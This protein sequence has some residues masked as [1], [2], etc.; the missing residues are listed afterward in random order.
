MQLFMFTFLW[1][2]LQ[3]EITKNDLQ[4]VLDLELDLA[5]LFLLKMRTKGVEW[6]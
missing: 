2:Q 6:I 5:Y 1:D 3:E 4:T